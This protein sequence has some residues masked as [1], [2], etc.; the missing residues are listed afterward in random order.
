MV[1]TARLRELR[2]AGEGI[3]LAAPLRSWFW[4]LYVKYLQLQQDLAMYLQL[5]QGSGE[6][7]MSCP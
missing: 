4:L 2:D 7:P 6:S 3:T 1:T 5:P